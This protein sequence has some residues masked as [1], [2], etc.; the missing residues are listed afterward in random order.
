MVPGSTEPLIEMSTRHLAGL[1]GGSVRK[2]DLTAICELLL[3]STACYK[4]SFPRVYLVEAIKVAAR[5]KA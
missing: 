1:K 4:D 2:A 5:S 3:V